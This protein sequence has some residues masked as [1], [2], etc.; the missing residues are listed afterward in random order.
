VKHFLSDE[1]F[2]LAAGPLAAL[3]IWMLADLEPGKPE[4]TKM[5]GVLVWMAIWWLTEVVPIAATSLLPV[6][7]LPVLGIADA[8]SVSGQYMDPILFLFIG[9]FMIAIAIEKWGLHQRMAL[10]ILMAAGSK[11]ENILLG[12][13]LTSYLLSMWIS[14]TATTMMLLTAVMALNKQLDK[15]GNNHLPDKA[16]LIGLAYAASIGGMATLVGTPT[17]MIFIREYTRLFPDEPAIHFNTWLFKALP[18]SLLVL[19][20]AYLILKWKFTNRAIKTTLPKDYFREAYLQLGKP[21][22]AQKAVG[23]IFMSTA[24]LWISRA[25]IHFGNFSIK[26][27]SSLFGN[28]DFLSDGAVAIAMA[29]LLFIIPSGKK[30]GEKLL[31]WKDAE[32]LPFGIILLFGGGF[33]LAMGVQVSGLSE[34]ITQG[35]SFAAGWPKVLFLL[36]MILMISTITE[37]ASNMTSIQ[38]MIPILIP[39]SEVVGWHP[40]QLLIPATI[41]ASM[42]FML[43]VATGP[44]TIIFGTGQLKVKDMAGAGILLNILSALLLT[45]YTAY[46]L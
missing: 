28:P 13:M 24:F 21:D 16:L 9:G 30:A 35:L 45:L 4:V 41:A 7:L 31:T 14:N 15:D 33:A 17:N 27:W 32:Q 22:F 1:R 38:L 6:V 2:Q 29:L 34:W 8:R 46:V 10:R 23:L 26:G 37:F 3:L 40:L 25:D 19:M 39:L 42:C 44:N 36:V 20:S 18:L 12:I 11:P 43:P 5:A